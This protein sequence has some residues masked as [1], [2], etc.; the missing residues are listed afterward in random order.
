MIEE[1]LKD[2]K[3]LV[4][5]VREHNDNNLEYLR[6]FYD[7][8]DDETFY[9]KLKLIKT[10]HLIS[11]NQT[12]MAQL[13][14]YRCNYIQYQNIT[15]R[16]HFNDLYKTFSKAD[17]EAL[18]ELRITY[19]L[20]IEQGDDRVKNRAKKIEENEYYKQ[21]TTGLYANSK[22]TIQ[23]FVNSK[24]KLLNYHE[25]YH[26]DGYLEIGSEG[27]EIFTQKDKYQYRCICGEKLTKVYHLVSTVTLKKFGNKLIMLKIGSICRSKF[28]EVTSLCKFCP[29]KVKD[30]YKIVEVNKKNYRCCMTC[31]NEKKCIKQSCK[32][33]TSNKYA[34]IC[35]GC[36]E[37]QVKETYPI[38]DGK[39]LFIP[40]I[41]EW[42]EN[43]NKEFIK[44]NT[45][46]EL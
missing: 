45:I 26:Y 30:N 3:K 11:K 23:D 43:D 14:Y 36:G 33:I 31:Y 29:N 8:H 46:N 15:K 7:I 2:Y 40:K 12:I 16:L 20:H 1:I 38:I 17:C 25:D 4:V 21:F 32:K 13:F 24:F 9:E 28:F 19:K 5:F 41:K 27:Q 39:G 44:Y 37:Q 35:E 6:Y 42:T 10:Q 22:L 34:S 18:E